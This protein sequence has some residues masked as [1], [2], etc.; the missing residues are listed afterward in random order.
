[1]FFVTGEWV[2]ADLRRFPVGLWQNPS[3]TAILFD[4]L[5]S[6]YTLH[7]SSFRLP[8]ELAYRSSREQSLET[9]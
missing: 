3:L 5:H 8:P 2:V 1:M 4:L 7:E 9:S 6:G